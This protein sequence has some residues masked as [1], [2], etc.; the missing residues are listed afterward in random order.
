MVLFFF[1]FRTAYPSFIPTYQQAFT[2]Y[3]VSCKKQQFLVF[4]I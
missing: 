4:F 2:T 3:Q 1:T